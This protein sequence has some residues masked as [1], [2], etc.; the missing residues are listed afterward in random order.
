MAIHMAQDIRSATAE[1]PATSKVAMK[2][3]W[4]SAN[5]YRIYHE[6]SKISKMQCPFG[7]TC[8]LDE[9]LLSQKMGVSENGCLFDHPQFRA[10]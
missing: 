6:E 7:H 1:D 5:T 8:R 9:F 3:W 2:S 10:V 4:Y